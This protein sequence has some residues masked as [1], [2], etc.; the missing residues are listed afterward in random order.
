MIRQPPRS[1]LS[2]SSAASDVYKR[3]ANHLVEGA[4]VALDPD[5]DFP[6]NVWW[7]EYVQ[8][9]CTKKMETSLKAKCSDAVH[10]LNVGQHW[11]ITGAKR[12]IE[13]AKSFC[14]LANSVRLDVLIAHD[15]SLIDAV[16]A[17]CEEVQAAIRDAAEFVVRLSEDNENISRQVDTRRA[18]GHVLRKLMAE[19]Q[20]MVN[21]GKLKADEQV[22]IE[23]ELHRIEK[24]VKSQYTGDTLHTN[25]VDVLR[26]TPLFEHM[27][28]EELDSL[29]KKAHTMTVKKGDQLEYLKEGVSQADGQ[30]LLV[31]LQGHANVSV[32]GK[33][34]RYGTVDGYASTGTV[35]GAARTFLSKSTCD[36][37]Y[38]ILCQTDVQVMYISYVES[39]WVAQLYETNDTELWHIA[40]VEVAWGSPDIRDTEPHVIRIMDDVRDHKSKIIHCIGHQQFQAAPR[41][42]ILLE[43]TVRV[44]DGNGEVKELSAVALLPIG[45][46][47]MM[48]GAVACVVKPGDKSKKYHQKSK[49]ARHEASVRLLT[50]TRSREGSSVDLDIP[51][52]GSKPLNL[53]EGH[54]L[55]G[56]PDIHPSPDS[57]SESEA[58]L[59][60][61]DFSLEAPATLVVDP[62]TKNFDFDIG[63]KPD[64]ENQL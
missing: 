5:H 28:K 47:E 53:T 56:S 25:Q 36:T 8:P 12:A 44:R 43:G 39:M 23:R 35:I 38:A 21:I 16:K 9:K 24:T 34:L 60:V 61:R 31:I 11:R 48:D 4:E 41:G 54:S 15:D 32:N 1:T 42:G 13:V 26:H 3:Q 57:F 45:P 52:L 2:S 63:D 19:T 27:S 64:A 22:M 7:S 58:E 10:C 55:P 20:A 18:L 14:A 50:Q 37:E 51:R 29:Q 40:A 46:W 62:A 6:L 59:G 17:T 30:H 33:P 49:E